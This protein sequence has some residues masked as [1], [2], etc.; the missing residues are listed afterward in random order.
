V[1]LLSSVQQP[2]TAKKKFKNEVEVEVWRKWQST[3]RASAA[4]LVQT[5]VLPNN[6][7][8]GVKTAWGEQKHT[9]RFLRKP[10]TPAGYF[11]QKGLR[12]VLGPMC[13]LLCPAPS[14]NTTGDK[15]PN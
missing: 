13:L 11:S 3:C 9:L 10:V 12:W 6:N 7:K 1:W 2:G 14:R 15:F 4:R 5:R 8:K